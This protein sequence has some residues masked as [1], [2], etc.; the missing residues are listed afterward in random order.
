MA[1]PKPHDP[2]TALSRDA[3]QAFDNVNG[4]VHAGF[5]PAHAKGI[6]LS[7]TFTPSAAAKALTKAPHAQRASTPVTVRFSDFAGVPMVPDNDPNGASPRGC[8]IRFHLGEHV[9][10]DIVAHSHD[11]FPARTAE[12]FVEFLRALAASGPGASR[13]SPIEVFLSTH[14]KALEFVQAPKPFPTSF[15]RESYFA[16]AAVKFVNGE[17]KAQFGRIRVRPAEGGEYLDEAAAASKGPNYLFDEIKE[18][19]AK[20][21]V[22]LNVMVQLA[23]PGDTVDDS[24]IHWPADREQVEFGVVELD[25][26]VPNDAAEQQKIIFDPI[27]RVDGIEVSGDPLL[28]PR[29][30][31]Y[32]LSGRRRRSA[33]GA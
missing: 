27:P 23:G 13:P 19:V 6:L 25:A 3:L 33:A 30:D 28:E 14:P 26:L 5:R 8:A 18:R 32:L 2:G 11:G 24:T 9:H 22:K 16:V 15:A 31:V 7:G 20:A 29:A 17:G 4:G 12:E 21:P 10:T 1:T